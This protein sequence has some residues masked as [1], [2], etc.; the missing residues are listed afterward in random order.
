MRPAPAGVPGELYIGGVQVARGYLG[1]PGLTAERF[2]PDPFSPVPGARLYRTGDRARWRADGA[3]EYLG[4]LDQQVKVRGFRIEP[5]EVEAALRQHPQVRDC[6]VVARDEAGGPRLVAYVVGDAEAEALRAHLRERLPEPMVPAAFVSLDALPLTP[7]GKLDRRA[8]PAP[9]YASGAE[10]YVA[11][12]TEVERALAE[13]WADVL[14]VER[15]GRLDGFFD[16]GGHSLLVMQMTARVRAA[17]GVQLSIRTV[18]A[19]PTLDALAGEIERGIYAD[20]LE[21][22]EDRAEEMAALSADTGD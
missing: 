21:M 3:L 7:N 4:R 8:L 2:V 20:I 13:I 6:A 15:V 16:L 19:A 9:E 17:F 14:G 1:R 5:G 22:P 12:E 10:R 18:F 11:P